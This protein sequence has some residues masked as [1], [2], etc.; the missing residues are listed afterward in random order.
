MQGKE[1]KF[2]VGVRH[3]NPTNANLTTISNL[4]EVRGSEAD[5]SMLAEDDDDDSEED[6]QPDDSDESVRGTPTRLPT[7]DRR[8][9]EQ[10]RYLQTLKL[11]SDC[12]PTDG[13]LSN[14]CLIPA[15]TQYKAVEYYLTIPV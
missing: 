2:F 13:T 10:R 6:W 7:I 5:P 11:D 12:F 8:S 4:R 9:T 15:T 1:A 3:P 14:L